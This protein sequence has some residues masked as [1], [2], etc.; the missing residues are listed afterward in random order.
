[1]LVELSLGGGGFFVGGVVVVV[2]VVVVVAVVV[3]LGHGAVHLGLHLLK[4]LGASENT[5]VGAPVP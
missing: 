2:V 5:M 4:W 1:M 3:Y